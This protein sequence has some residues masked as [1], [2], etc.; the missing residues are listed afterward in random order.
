M[1]TPQPPDYADM[2]DAQKLAYLQNQYA[3]AAAAKEV[4]DGRKRVQRQDLD[5]LAAEIERLEAKVRKS[6]RMQ[7]IYSRHTRNK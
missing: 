4:T 5:K 1:P 3:E 6:S 2:T 7:T